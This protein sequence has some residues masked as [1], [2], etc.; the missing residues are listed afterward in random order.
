MNWQDKFDELP[1]EWRDHLDQIADRNH[2]P[3]EPMNEINPL[4]AAINAAT[5]GKSTAYVVPNTAGHQ[6]VNLFRDLQHHKSVNNLNIHVFTMTDLHHLRGLDSVYYDPH[7]FEVA[8]MIA[9]HILDGMATHAA[10]D[11]VL[12]AYEGDGNDWLD[13]GRHDKSAGLHTPY[14]VVWAAHVTRW[15]P[16]GSA[17][18]TLE[19]LISAEESAV[20]KLPRGQLERLHDRGLVTPAG[21]VATITDTELRRDHTWKPTDRATEY[22]S[23]S[24]VDR[25]ELLVTWARQDGRVEP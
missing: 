3:E 5:T 6:H 23:A 1:A 9:E 8:E 13:Q 18:T 20:L 16:H 15:G 24:A 25:L 7:C 4:Q 14:V 17:A 2:Q 21:S 12:R 19:R 11:S 10:I 22:V